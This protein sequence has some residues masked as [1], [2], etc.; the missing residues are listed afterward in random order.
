MFLQDT[1]FEP[2]MEN[3]ITAEW[4]YKIYFASY[5]SA[6]R[7]VAVLF[8]NTFEFKVKKTLVDVENGN[9]LFVLVEIKGKEY[10]LVNLY[11]PNKDSPEF[12]KK[13][14]YIIVNFNCQHRVIAG[15]WNL[16]LDPSLDYEN[17]KNIN[18]EKTQEAVLQMMDNLDF[19]DIW[20]EFNPECLRF[21]W[22]RKFPF[23]RVG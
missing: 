9:Y 16:V 21:T 18:N 13:L 23:N 15:D 3:Y 4:G 11:G 1:H 14:N 6:S 22:R 20:R 7:G 5:T 8:N 10:L 12:Y 2:K 17:Y 19:Y